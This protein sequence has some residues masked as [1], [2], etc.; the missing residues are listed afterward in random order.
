M[1]G[2]DTYARQN[3]WWA[4]IVMVASTIIV[5]EEVYKLIVRMVDRRGV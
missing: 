2:T 3:A 4:L 1:P 5:A